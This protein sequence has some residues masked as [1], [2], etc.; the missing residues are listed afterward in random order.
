MTSHPRLRARG[1]RRPKLAHDGIHAIVYAPAHAD[2]VERELAGTPM[3]VEQ[4]GSIKQVMEALL[5][6]PPPRPQYLI[7]DVEQM[8]VGELLELHAI[9]EQGWFG[10]VIGLGHVALSL[11]KSLGIDRTLDAGRDSLRHIALAA[12][13]PSLATTIRMPK[14]TG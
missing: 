11:R 9:R 13:K 12:A 8:S 10:T 3:T 4:A 6:T 5:G 14:I 2:W 1:T 7:V